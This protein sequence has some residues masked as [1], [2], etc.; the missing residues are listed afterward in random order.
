MAETLSKEQRSSWMARVKSSNTTPERYVRR[1][2]WAAGFRYR[3][4]ERT[5]KDPNVYPPG[6]DAQRVREII[7]YHDSLTDEEWIAE[8]EVAFENPNN[9]V[10]VIP[11]E[12]VPAVRELLARH[13]ADNPAETAAG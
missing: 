7:K 12:L 3:L 4:K 6:L 2:L 5:M 9:T 10:M 13:T 1:E 11:T 8:D